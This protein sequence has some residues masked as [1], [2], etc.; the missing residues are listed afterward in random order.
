[1]Q[2]FKKP[3]SASYCTPETT[4]R[5]SLNLLI[6]VA[7]LAAISLALDSCAEGTPSAGH[8]G[9]EPPVSAIQMMQHP[10]TGSER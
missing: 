5:F 10:E 3:T 6:V 4:L 7:L 8:H 2:Q 9:T 1:M